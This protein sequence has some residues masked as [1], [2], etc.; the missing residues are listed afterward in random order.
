MNL[1]ECHY[2]VRQLVNKL[3]GQ[4]GANL[5]PFQI[6]WALNRSTLIVLK[7]KYKFQEGEGF[8]YD[9]EARDNLSALYVRSPQ[10]QVALVPTT[11][12]SKYG[13][14]YQ[15]KLTNLTYPYIH[16]I[17]A[18]AKITST[19]GSKYCGLTEINRNELD[20]VLVDPNK[21][22]DYKWG[23]VICDIGKDSS[24][25][26]GLPGSI[27]IYSCDDFTVDEVQVDYLKLPREVYYGG[28]NSLSGQYTTGDPQVEF[29][30]GGVDMHEEICRTAATL[31]TVSLQD[32]QLLQLQLINNQQS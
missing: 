17:G 20:T 10:D 21:K 25:E 14:V 8:E 23:K 30:F 4:G 5:L 9:Q 2:T 32:P 31:L 18:T 26:L 11:S 1:F 7:R 29:D 6:D 24:T 22:S 3:G 12:G 13:V 19:C 28:Y 15:V 16:L 27:Y